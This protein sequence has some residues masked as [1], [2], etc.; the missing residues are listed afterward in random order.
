MVINFFECILALE[1]LADLDGRW[2][3]PNAANFETHEVMKNLY[4]FEDSW[5]NTVYDN[6]GEKKWLLNNKYYM[7]VV[8]ENGKVFWQDSTSGNREAFGR[9]DPNFTPEDLQAL[10]T[11][12]RV[13]IFF[14]DFFDTPG[15]CC[16]VFMRK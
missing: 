5:Y 8:S 16:E 1:T 10:L 3:I 7:D 9:W 2:E 15:N 11:D 4:G 12:Y 14:P 6:G 13:G